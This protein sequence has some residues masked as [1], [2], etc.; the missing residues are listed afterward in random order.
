M[1]VSVL[2]L[3][4]RA[5]SATAWAAFG[6]VLLYLAVRLFDAID[7]IDYRGEILKGNTA[8]AIQMAALVLGTADIIVAAIV[9]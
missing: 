8:A 1:N 3:L 5:G 6:V 4:E 2:H 9:T 7:P